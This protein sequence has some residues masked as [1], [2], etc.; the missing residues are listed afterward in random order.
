MLETPLAA[1]DRALSTTRRSA[2][3]LVSD[4]EQG[5]CSPGV[6]GLPQTT[7]HPGTPD[8]LLCCPGWQT[9]CQQQPSALPLVPLFSP[10]V[11]LPR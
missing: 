2:C 4:S 3:P 10:A 1:A 5:R 7:E 9:S 6:R 11:R 8:L